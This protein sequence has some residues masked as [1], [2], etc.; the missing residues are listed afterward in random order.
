M[1]PGMATGLSRVH[2]SKRTLGAGSTSSNAAG[3]TKKQTKKSQMSVSHRS[4]QQ[5]ASATSTQQWQRQQNQQNLGLGGGGL[6]SASVPSLDL[7]SVNNSMKLQAL[8]SA[9]NDI[10]LKVNDQILLE[11][12]DLK[13]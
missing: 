11:N 5:S 10:L 6:S 13:A 8:S 2:S 4:L 3:N 12:T 7:S 1:P 9:N